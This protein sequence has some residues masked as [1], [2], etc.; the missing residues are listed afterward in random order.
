MSDDLTFFARITKIDKDKHI[1][2]GIAT[3]ESVDSEIG[4]TTV[5]D[6]VDY[7]ATKKAVKGW[8]QWRNIREMHQPLAAGVAE[9]IKLDDKNRNMF[10][11][12]KIV[13]PIAWEKCKEGVYKGFSV[14]GR[15]LASINE[16]RQDLGGYVRRITDY[17]MTEISLVDSPANPSAKFTMVKRADQQEQHVPYTAA[18]DAWRGYRPTTSYNAKHNLG[19]FLEQVRKDMRPID[20]TQRKM[21]AGDNNSSYSGVN[22]RTVRNQEQI[23][24]KQ[25]P[26]A[27]DSEIYGF[28]LEL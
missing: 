6:I 8:E 1:V 18:L 21:A 12:A 10:I 24:R 28:L 14:G 7:D 25:A 27:S 15:R 19:I 22:G 9:D 13:D 11:R 17:V 23:A 4:A 2:E 3:D 16:Y 20:L 5:G 26:D